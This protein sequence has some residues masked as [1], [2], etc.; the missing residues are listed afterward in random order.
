MPLLDH[1]HPP[2]GEYL[3]WESLLSAW[4]TYLADALND[5]QCLPPLYR[6]LELVHTKPGLGLPDEV[7]IR[8]HEGRSGGSV[9]G[10]IE[11]ITPINKLSR[12]E[13]RAFAGKCARYLQEGVSVVLIDIVTDCRANLH[14]EVLRLLGMAEAAPSPDDTPLYAAAYG[15]VLRQDG[16]E[17]AVWTEP[18]A[19]GEPLPTMPLR[20]T[21]DLFVPVDFE[22]PYQK[23]C[24]RRRLA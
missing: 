9:V 5:S 7:E 15:S 23:T 4:A 20:L 1:F 12:A 6:A 13:C 11:L 14:G 8:M 22:S 21:G 16:P 18:V 2:I 3:P 17:I 19:V 10:A 24:R